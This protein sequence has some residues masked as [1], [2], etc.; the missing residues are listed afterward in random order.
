MPNSRLKTIKGFYEKSLNKK[1]ALKFKK[2]ATIIYI[3]CDLYK[4]TVPILKFIIPFCKKEPSL[5]LMIGIAFGVINQKDRKK[6]GQ[7]L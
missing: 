2:K 3:D 7:I 4:S 1:L 5:H 6:H